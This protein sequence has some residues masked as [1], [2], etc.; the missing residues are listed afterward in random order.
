MSRDIFR[1][2]GEDDATTKDPRSRCP[3]V[4]LRCRTLFTERVSSSSL[5]D[6]SGDHIDTCFQSTIEI[7]VAKEWLHGIENSLNTT[8][9]QVLFRSAAS[10]DVHFFIPSRYK[11]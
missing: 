2:E 9:C 6:L 11:Q 1:K 4:I 7:V 3:Q 10:A 5:G 8:I